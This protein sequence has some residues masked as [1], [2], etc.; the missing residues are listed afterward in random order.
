MATVRINHPDDFEQ[1]LSRF[2]Q[3]C[4]IEHIIKDYKNRTRFESSRDERIRKQGVAKKRSA[5][6]KRRGLI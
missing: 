2:K 5:N 4:K 3:L 1:Q 6:T